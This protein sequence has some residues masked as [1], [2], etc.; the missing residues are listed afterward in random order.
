VPSVAGANIR[1]GGTGM[2]AGIWVGVGL[3]M[4]LAC[5]A[6]AQDTEKTL[7]GSRPLTWEGDLAAR[8][9]AGVDA[10]LTR[11]TEASVRTRVA[12]WRRDTTSPAA[13]ERSVAANRERFRRF[14][15]AVDPRVPFEDLELLAT[16]GRNAEIATGRG[17]RVLAVRWPVFP[18][19]HGEGLLLEPDRVA[20]SV[21]ALPDCDWTPEA[22]I[23]LSPGVPAEAQYARRLAEN[24]CRVLIP[25]LLDRTDTYSGT[26]LVRFTNQPHREYVYRGA[27]EL[28]RHVIGYEVQK[29]AA[30][31]DWLKRRADGGKVGVFGYGEGG[32]LALYAG[33]ADP[34]VDLTVVSGYFG[35]RERVW[36]EP[37]YRNVWSLLREFGDAE[38]ASLAAPRG[39]IVEHATAPAVAGPPP[40]RDGRSGAAPGAIVTPSR[41]EVEAELTRLG[42]LTRGLDFTPALTVGEGLPGNEATLAET[43]R[44]LGAGPLTRSGP[45]PQGAAP[46]ARARQ[47]RQ[48]EELVEHNGRLLG[49]AEYRRGEFWARADRASVEKWTESTRS[50]RDHFWEETIGRLPAAS[51]PPNPRTRLIY[52]E[53]KYAGYEVVLDVWPDVF[54]YGIL[55]LPKGMKDGEK[56]P[57]VVCQHGLEGRPQDV[58]DSKVD[59]PAYHHYAATLAQRGFV[60]FAP[61]NL[62]IGQD[63]FRVLQRKLNPLK[64]SLFSVIA[65]QHERI[66]EWLKAQPYVDPERI[67]FYGLSYGGKSA[68]RLPAMLEGYCLSIC[69]ADYNEWIWKNASYR[70]R[71]SYVFTGEYEIFEWDLGNTFNYAEMSWLIFPRPFMVERGHDDGVA[72]DEWVNY[73]WAKTFQ[74]YSRLGLAD[75]ARIEFFNGPHTINGKGTFEFLHHHLKWP[76]P[77]E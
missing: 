31:V 59:N 22:L 69:S 39:L 67:A 8:M 3:L 41:A 75:R 76:A 35:P 42:E 1:S 51:L 58:A 55:L 48:V 6:G 18:G 12:L 61:Q 20:A 4:A 44:V 56:R 53:P 26:P 63:R 13:Y 50:Y 25:T 2:Q 19:V 16:V 30:A 33:A 11:E 77:A 9:V 37:I 68:M 60:V 74:R 52:D 54:A 70:S 24:G 65:R 57:V 14:I 10:Y 46:D 62:Y 27:F 7:P 64:K 23:G 38:I 49:E 71:Y 47:R 32:L 5:A 17:Y 73:E 72:P 28:G 15:G 45:A 43:L 66:L 40:A 34:R 21:V 29:V 36:S